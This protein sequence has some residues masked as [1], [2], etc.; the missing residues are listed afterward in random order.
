[1]IFQPRFKHRQPTR[2]ST[3]FNKPEQIFDYDESTFRDDSGKEKVV[4]GCDTKYANKIHAGSEVIPLISVGSPLPLRVDHFHSPPA[5][6]SGITMM[7]QSRSF[8]RIQ[9]VVSVIQDL[10]TLEAN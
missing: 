3:L 5:G 2:D 4:V 9:P 1:M 8:D 10:D 7:R 6:G